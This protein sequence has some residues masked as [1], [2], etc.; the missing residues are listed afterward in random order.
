MHVCLNEQEFTEHM[1]HYTHTPVSAEAFP[2]RYVL[3]LSLPLL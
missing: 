3:A 1:H 2:N